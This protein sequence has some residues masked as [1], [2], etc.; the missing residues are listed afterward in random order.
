MA[1]IY[2]SELSKEIIQGAKIE[3]SRDNI[4][5]QIAE[6]VVPVMEVN[7]KMLRRVNV[8]FDSNRTTSGTATFATLSSDK[9]FFL[10]GFSVCIAKDAVCDTATGTAGLTIPLVDGNNKYITSF[11]IITLTAQQ[12]S[13][14]VE[15][16]TPIPC[17]R[18]GTITMAGTFGAG[19]YIRSAT[20]R[21]YYTE[22]S[23]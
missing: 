10:T 22:T 6:K 13:E 8:M 2:N 23:A 20:I 16:K 1:T 9:D 21:G 17:K 15:V 11:S 5:S 18:G 7:P 14:S 4:P 12:F 3:L 19:V